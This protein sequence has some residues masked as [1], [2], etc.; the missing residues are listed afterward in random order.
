MILFNDLH[1]LYIYSSIWQQ[2]QCLFNK[3]YIGASQTGVVTIPYGSEDD[4]QAAT[5]TA[6][7]I[8]VSVDASSNAFR[9]SLIA[10]CNYVPLIFKMALFI[11]VLWRR[12]VWWAKLLQ[13]TI[14]ADSFHAYHRLW[15]I[16]GKR[17][18]AGQEQVF[19][20]ATVV[21]E[22]SLLCMHTASLSTAGAPTGG[23]KVTSWWLGGRATSVESPQQQV[24]QHFRL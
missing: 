8:S 18:L 9:V 23:W 7:P 6:G 21:Q 17:L 22:P 1:L 15:D 13:R 14:K 16:Q 4:L 12:C 3:N 10:A 5:A 24:F 20:K 19:T 2:G 11:P